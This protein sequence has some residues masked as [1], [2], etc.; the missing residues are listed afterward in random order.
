VLVSAGDDDAVLGLPAKCKWQVRAGSTKGKDS[1]K[2]NS[3]RVTNS[4]SD[5]L[6]GLPASIPIYILDVD[7]RSLLSRKSVHSRVMY[8]C[9][10]TH[11]F[12]YYIYLLVTMF[13]SS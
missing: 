3:S 11:V 12:M 1:S 5:G 9:S 7:M 8:S 10:C 6:H 13:F 4:S 2:R